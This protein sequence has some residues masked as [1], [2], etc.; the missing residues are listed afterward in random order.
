MAPQED[1][2][3]KQKAPWTLLSPVLFEQERA[4]RPGRKQEVRRLRERK[5]SYILSVVCKNDSS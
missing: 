5:Q 3:D 4:E 2:E 1:R